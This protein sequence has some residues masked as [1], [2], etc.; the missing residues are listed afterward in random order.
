M[1]KSGL[2]R[3]KAARRTM[4]GIS[5]PKEI[6]RTELVYYWMELIILLIRIQTG[7]NWSINILLAKTQTAYL[8]QMKT[9]N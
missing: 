5:G 6:P 1:S 8:N 9:M 2:A 3:L 7:Q 4:L